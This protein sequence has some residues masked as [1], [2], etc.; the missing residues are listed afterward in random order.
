VRCP[1]RSISTQFFLSQLSLRTLDGGAVV[2]KHVDEGVVADLAYRTAILPNG[3]IYFRR[4]ARGIAPGH[5]QMLFRVH[6]AQP[7]SKTGLCIH[8]AVFD[9]SAGEV[10]TVTSACCKTNPRVFHG[11]ACFQDHF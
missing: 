8:D 3:Q 2:P 6:F 7:P 4:T 10:V 9:T 11:T 5:K 1:C